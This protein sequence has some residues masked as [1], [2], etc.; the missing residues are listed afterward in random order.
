M[1]FDFGRAIIG[2]VAGA[3]AGIIFIAFIPVAFGIDSDHYTVTKNYRD[4]N[5]PG[6]FSSGQVEGKQCYDTVVELNEPYKTYCERTQ[7]I[8]ALVLIFGSFFYYGFLGRGK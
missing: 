1:K 4:C 2:A 3:I 6:L 8:T 5:E 7:A